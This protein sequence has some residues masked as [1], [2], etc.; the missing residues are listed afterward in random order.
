HAP[1][2]DL[3][4]IGRSLVPRRRDNV[5]EAAVHRFDAG[6]DQLVGFGRWTFEEVRLTREWSGLHA[7]GADPEL[8]QSPLEARQNP[9][10]SDRPRDGRWLGVNVIGGGRDPIA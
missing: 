5:E 3:V 7:V 9:E 2:R 10:H 4:D 8:L 1:L 6:L